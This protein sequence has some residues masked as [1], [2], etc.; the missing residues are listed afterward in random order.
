MTE[1][2][3][4]D[5]CR[6]VCGLC[7]KYVQC[8]MKV[9]CEI[10]RSFLCCR[11]C[12]G[13]YLGYV[14]NMLVQD[15]GSLWNIMLM[16]STCVSCVVRLVLVCMQGMSEICVVQSEGSLWNIMFMKSSRVYCVKVLLLVCIWAVS[17]ICVVLDKG[18]L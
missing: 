9:I 13:L 2:V 1:P 8:R 3:L 14:R 16:K 5:Q 15:E 6:I 17:A 18:G 12:T 11:V 4:Q 7:Q 10:F